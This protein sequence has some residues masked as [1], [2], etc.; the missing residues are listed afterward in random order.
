MLFVRATV[1][2]IIPRDLA[3]EGRTSNCRADELVIASQPRANQ[4]WNY[5]LGVYGFV[6]RLVHTPK[7]VL[8]G[9]AVVPLHDVCILSTCLRQPLYPTGTS[10]ISIYATEE[11]T[12]R[13]AVFPH[14]MRSLLEWDAA[15]CKV[16]K[17]SMPE[18]TLHCTCVHVMH[19]HLGLGPGA[20][21]VISILRWSRFRIP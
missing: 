9:T 7:P 18:P 20:Q 4:Y 6:I 10:T 12:L 16:R 5:R 11:Q 21:P 19:A 14:G 1:V 2:H 17:A 8:S 3:M 13:A 15:V